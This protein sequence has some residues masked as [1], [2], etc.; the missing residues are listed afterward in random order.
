MGRYIAPLV[1]IAIMYFGVKQLL[2]HFS[3]PEYVTMSLLD[4]HKNGIGDTKYIEIT[5]AYNLGEFIYQAN[6][7]SN[8]VIYINYPLISFS[9]E[10]FTNQD[11]TQFYV[12]VFVKDNDVSSDCLRDS[13]CIEAGLVAVKGRVSEG[14]VPKSELDLMQEGYN[15]DPN[16]IEI[17][18]GW[19]KP[20]LWGGLLMIIIPGLLLL[21]NL[22]TFRKEK[23]TDE[24]V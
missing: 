19:E 1:F 13:S 5:D 18:Q 9:E 7:N 4:I 2:L 20:G 15:V 16:P 12:K 22:A 8:S 21:A 6:E 3:N 14:G 23:G 11:T 17:E 24:M 10:G